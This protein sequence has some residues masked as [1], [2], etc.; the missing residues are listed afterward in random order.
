M[1][2]RKKQ[3]L[4]NAILSQIERSRDKLKPGT[5]HLIDV[6]HDAWCD[7]L[8]GRGQCNCNPEVQTPSRVPSLQDN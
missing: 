7:L 8:A 6:R 3:L 1:K 2:R 5:V 4:Q